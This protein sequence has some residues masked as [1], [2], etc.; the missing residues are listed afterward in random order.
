MIARPSGRHIVAILLL[1]SLLIGGHLSDVIAQE[2]PSPVEVELAAPQQAGPGQVIDVLLKYNVVDPNAGAIINYNLSGPG[3][4]WTR[5]PEPPNPLVNTW[6][7]KFNPAQ[8]TIKIQVRIDEGTDGQKL[9]HQVEVKWGPKFQKYVA[10]TTIKYVPPA[11]TPTPTRRP[12]PRPTQPLP[13]PVKPTLDLTS[14]TFVSTGAEVQRLTTAEANQEIALDVLYTSSGTVENV[15][16]RV[17]FEP[18]LVNID[19]LEHTDTGY[20]LTIARGYADKH[21][22][23]GRGRTARCQPDL[24]VERSGQRRQRHR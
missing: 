16:V 22:R 4:I 10:E 17:W 5:T 14:A 11:P 21:S 23:P 7:P 15:T 19:G 13:T 24:T 2:E 20:V 6:G 3:M 9:Q 1:T 8:G 18:D 12:Q